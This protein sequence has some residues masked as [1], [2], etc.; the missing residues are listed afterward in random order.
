MKYFKLLLLITLAT[1]LAC[2]EEDTRPSLCLDGFCDGM[3][4]IPYLSL[5][6]I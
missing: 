5:I 4:S 6:H 2:T 3:L 1:T